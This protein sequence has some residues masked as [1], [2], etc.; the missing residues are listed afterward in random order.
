MK[1]R[2]K[3]REKGGVTFHLLYVF[4]YYIWG[5]AKVALQLFVWKIIQ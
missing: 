3:Y 1:E 4:R 2:E 5:G